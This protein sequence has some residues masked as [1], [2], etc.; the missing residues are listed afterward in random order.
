MCHLL[1]GSFRHAAM[2]VFDNL[3]DVVGVKNAGAATFGGF[4][5]WQ[6]QNFLHKALSL[7]S[8][9]DDYHRDSDIIFFFTV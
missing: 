9:Q 7:V 1:L 5:K 8:L 3:L 6:L 2:F 4:C